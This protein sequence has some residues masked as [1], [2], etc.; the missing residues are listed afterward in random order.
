[1]KIAMIG[2]GGI[3]GSYRQSLRRL[4][5]PVAAVCDIDPTRAGQVAAEENAHSYTDYRELLER[6][7]PDVVFVAIPPYAHTSQVADAARAGCAVF[8]AKPIALNVATAR[9]IA[10]AISESGG[11]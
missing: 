1:M 9:P 2:V 10:A 5:Q 8:V 6:E 11:I 3:A 7:K 4:E